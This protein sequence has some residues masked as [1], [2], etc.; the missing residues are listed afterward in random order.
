MMVLMVIV[1]RSL[2]EEEEKR[3]RDYGGD[4]GA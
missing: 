2:V 3:I 4:D 1:V